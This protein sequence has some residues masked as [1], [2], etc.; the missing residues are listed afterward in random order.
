[1]RA[2]VVL[3]DASSDAGYVGERLT[4]RS[5][6]LVPHVVC[7]SPTEP[8][9]DVPFP[10]VSGFDALVLFGAVWS[11]YDRA[12]IGSWIDRELEL[13]RHAHHTHVPVLGVCFGA[14]ALAAALGGTVSRSPEMEVGWFHVDTDVDAI[15]PGPWFQWHGDRFTVPAGAK[16]IARGGVGP[17]AFVAG[18][19]L[20]V[21]FHPEVTPEIVE[22]WAGYGT[23]TLER[24]GIERDAL[25]RATKQHAP[26]ARAHAH[27][28]VDYF[29]DDVA[30]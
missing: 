19:S 29:L 10:D 23:D 8:H 14:Q 7:A 16:E 25:A 12:T 24:L 13:L 17:Q 5:V 21:Q 30:R 9:S 26:V 15:E 4:D 20:G 2:L 22:H 27:R 1:V 28:L 18:R 3:H 6:E 11:V